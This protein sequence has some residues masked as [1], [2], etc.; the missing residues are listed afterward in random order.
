[1]GASPYK[2]LAKVVFFAVLVVRSF[3]PQ[4]TDSRLKKQVPVDP[5]RALNVEM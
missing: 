1:M 2:L 4:E 5:D 3:T